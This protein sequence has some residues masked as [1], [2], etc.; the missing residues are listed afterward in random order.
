VNAHLMTTYA[1]ADLAFERGEGAYLY[2]TDGT[3]YLDFGCGVAVT[4]LGHAHPHLVEKL[5][6]QI[7][8]LWHSSNLYRIPEQER[9]ADRLVENSFAAMAFFCNSGAEAVEAGIKLCRKFHD[10][11]GNPDRYR[12]ITF[13]GNF[14][15][16][17]LTTISAGN[18]ATHR[19]GYEP[20][21]DGFDPV[22][23]GNLNEVRAAVSDRT[24]AILVEPVQGEGGIRPADPEFLEGLRA[25][26]DEYGLLLFF[27]EVQTGFGRTGTLWGYQHS[28]ITPDVMAVAKA[29]GGGFPCGAL[30]A[31]EAAGKSFVPGSHGSTFGGNQLAMTAA[32]AVLDV[33]LADGFLPRAA[34]MGD[35]LLL[36]A[37]QVAAKHPKVIAEV[38]GRGLMVGL[39]CV[40]PSANVNDALRRHKVLAVLAGDNVV[41][42]LPPLV[43]QDAH[44][45]EAMAALDAACVE[46]GK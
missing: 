3:R 12:I 25:V 33:M 13:E 23:F 7:G 36:R 46:L 11:N 10:D 38:R 27:D 32:N 15:G 24:A 6:A 40:A 5:T 16:R 1:R 17:T 35:K 45:E 14:H 2:A 20:I 39:K 4:S 8:K 29:L 43:I 31:T 42:L 41:R 22:A 19:K 34:R 18:N 30:L 37:R 9:L 21:V 28:A 44:I 26:C